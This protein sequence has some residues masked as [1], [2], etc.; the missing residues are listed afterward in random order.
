MIKS[1]FVLLF[2]CQLSIAECQLPYWQQQVN[3]TIDVTLNDK[4]NTLDAFEKIEYTNNSPDTLYFIWFHLWMNAYKNDR[5]AFSEQMLENGNTKF[6][7]SDKEDKGY[8]N[9]LDFKVNNITAQTEDHPQHIDIVKLILPSPLAP[10]QKCMITTPFHEKLPYNFSRGGHDGQSYQITQWY[11]KPAVYDKNGWHPIPYLDQGEFYSE[12]GSFDVRITVP[13]NYVVAATGEL[14]NADEKEWLKT[15]SGFSFIP[16]K[17]KV[18]TGSETFKIVTE[19]F[20]PSDAQT[21]TLVYKQN[22]V[23][24]F[25]WFADKRFL[26]NH[27]TCKLSS[28]KVIDVYTYF[29]QQQKKYWQNSMKYCKD[30]A[31]FYSSQLGEYPYNI[32]QAVQGPESFGGGMEYPTIT[33]ISPVRSGIDLDITTTHEIGHNWLY[34]IL[35]SNERDHPWMD[36]GINTYYE[37]L[38][39]KMKYGGYDTKEK[40]YLETKEITKTDQPIETISENFSA[41]NYDLVAYYKTAEWMRY[42]RS[43]LGDDTF[44]K[45]MQNYY[46]QWKFKHPQPEDL[47]NIFSETTGKRPDTLFDHLSKKGILPN[48]IRKGSKFV[49]IPSPKMLSKY[50]HSDAKNIFA[51]G[52]A[53]GYNG[54]DKYMLGAF[55]TNY[56]LPPTPFQFFISSLYSPVSQRWSG[57]G[58]AHYTFFPEGKIRK[59][60]LFAGFANFSKDNFTDTAGKTLTFAFQKLAP[61]FRLTFNEKDPRS[62]LHRFIQWKTFFIGEDGLHFYRDSVITPTDTIYYDKYNVVRDHTVLNQLRF[63]INNNRVLYPYSGEL[64]LEQTNQFIRAGFTGNYFFN[65]P[66]GGGMNMRLFAG[67]FIF[68]TP[69]TLNT[70]FETSR[71]HLNMSGP[72]GNEDYTYSDYFIGRNKNNT[73][74]ANQQIMMRDGGFKIRTDQL[75]SEV[76]QT[77]DWLIA[78]NFN[79]TLPNIFPLNELPFKLPVKIFFDC[80]TYAEAWKKNSD[81]DHFL[82]DA[83]IQIPLLKETVNLYIPVLYSTVYK[84]Y[85]SSIIPRDYHFLRTLS[86]NIDISNLMFQKFNSHFSFLD[87]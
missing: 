76:G 19:R 36:E 82:F 79:T 50:L 77:D 66:K 30:A 34:G 17:H 18:S 65:Y 46:S 41:D 57:I 45:A 64:R 75:A 38:Y 60:D 51:V 1:I 8:I 47:K 21:K 9:R 44:D 40:I 81:L 4:D 10:G 7:F 55:A 85:I 80:G 61:G 5:T 6:Y 71:Y 84:D 78:M 58:T 42:A 83:G 23:H 28:G 39:T 32:V 73:S 52:P 26:V 13:K 53:S 22:D 68:T 86:F 27:D 2:I 59:I 63:V 48:E 49:F 24:D 72:T 62:T 56:K 16:Q 14:Q 70:E 54:Y 35:A 15:R 25:A 37:H 67:K 74:P 33:I 87:E 12:F 11:P 31:R 20:P 69:K 29:T 43:V 3:Y